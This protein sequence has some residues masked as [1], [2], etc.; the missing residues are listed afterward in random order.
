MRCRARRSP[1]LAAACSPARS[2]PR[3]RPPAGPARARSDVSSDD[4]HDD[5]KPRVVGGPD[6]PAADRIAAAVAEHAVFVFMKGHPSAP[7][8]GFSN[9]ACRVLDA[10]GARYGSADVLA[11]AELR[12]GVKQF[13]KWPTIPQIFIGGEFVGGSDILMAMHTSGE[14]E[15][16]L[17]KAAAADGGK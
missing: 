11:D 16:A 17:A 13:T 12:E 5:F 7:M 8:C 4:S 9:M 10:H 3:A 1:P 2:P 15:A 14:L 6:A